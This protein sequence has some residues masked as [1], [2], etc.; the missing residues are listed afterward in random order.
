MVRALRMFKGTVGR[1][2]GRRVVV[3]IGLALVAGSI[4]G[5]LLSG[6][7]PSKVAAGAASSSCEPRSVQPSRHV[8]DSYD[9][10]VLSFNPS[11]YLTLGNQTSAMEPD[12]SGNGNNGLY[13]PSSDPSDFAVLPNGDSATVFNGTNEYVQVPS[14]AS[15]SITDTGCLTVEAWVKPTVLQFPHNQGSGYV[16]ILGKGVTGKQEY[17]LRMYSYSNSEVP[18]RPNRISAYAFSLA[19]GK[20]SGAYFQEKVYPGQWIMVAFVIDSRPS[21]GWPDGYIAIYKNGQLRRS[22]VSLAQFNVT[23]EASDAPFRVGT[24]DLESFFEGAI[25]K[26]A[27][28]NSV[29]SAQDILATYNAMV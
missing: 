5:I 21:T 12:L 24:R 14:T 26:I 20:G 15:L 19:G 29:L 3:F 25:G 10:Q 9:R 7:G 13:E 16:Y 1:R 6:S 28:Y 2:A 27:V 17:A 22:R 23:P 4:L 18:Q 8:T 11:L